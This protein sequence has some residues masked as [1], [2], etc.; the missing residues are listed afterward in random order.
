MRYI[1]IIALLLTLGICKAQEL[2]GN[3]VKIVEMKS[4][5]YTVHGDGFYLQLEMAR[6]SAGVF[7]NEYDKKYLYIQGD[8]AKAILMLLKHFNENDEKLEAA[9][10]VLSTLTTNGQV[11]NWK[12]FHKAV[13]AYQAI[14]KDE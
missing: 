8:T 3:S 14:N 6:D 12:A 5:S 1:L 11:T 4:Y 10:N 7:V 2:T 13:K 9:N